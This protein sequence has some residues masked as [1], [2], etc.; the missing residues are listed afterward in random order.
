MTQDFHLA[1]QGSLFAPSNMSSLQFYFQFQTDLTIVDSFI[2][3]IFRSDPAVV[4]A[5]FIDNIQ[6]QYHIYCMSW[7]AEAIE[8]ISKS[9][10]AVS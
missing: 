2:V 3:N 4:V 6:Q 1:E 8:T 5:S 7:I 10:I 9:H